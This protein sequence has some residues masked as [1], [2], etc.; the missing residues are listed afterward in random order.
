VSLIERRKARSKRQCG[1]LQFSFHLACTHIYTDEWPKAL[2][3]ALA[4]AV[5]TENLNLHVVVVKSTKD[6]A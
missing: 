1:N 2:R 6:L 3:I 5:C 4:M